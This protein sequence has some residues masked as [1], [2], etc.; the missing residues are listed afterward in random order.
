M[1]KGASLA[2]KGLRYF[3]NITECYSLECFKHTT[4]VQGRSQ[5]GN[6]PPNRRLSGFLTEKWLCWDIVTLFSLP[7]V[8]CGP[9]I[10]QK[11]VGGWSSARTPLGELTTLPQTPSRL[12]RG[13]TF[14]S[15][16]SLGASILAPSAL[17]FYAPQC[18]ILAT[19]LHLCINLSLL[20]LGGV[21][22]FAPEHAPV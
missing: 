4:P 16:T 10:C 21:R 11:C 19:P 9:Q 1:L 15:P 13:H 20:G 2:E 22:R 12:G 8:F 5:R 14:P 18:K 7:E 17:S 6:L 3:R